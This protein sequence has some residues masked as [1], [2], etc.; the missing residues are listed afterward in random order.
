MILSV[1][2]AFNGGVEESTCGRCS[3][4]VGLVVYDEGQ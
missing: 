2:T 4:K 1:M 3:E